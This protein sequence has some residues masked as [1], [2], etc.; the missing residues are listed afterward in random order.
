MQKV[1]IHN[2]GSNNAV[3]FVITSLAGLIKWTMIPYTGTFM[4]NATWLSVL[5]HVAEAGIVALAC[6]FL[7][8]L[9]K[10]GAKLLLVK[11]KKYFKSKK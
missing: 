3:W 6:G 10:E 4:L 2:E 11:V 7:G 9:G 8:V 5:F 1:M